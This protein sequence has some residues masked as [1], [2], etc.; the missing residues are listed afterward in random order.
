MSSK[1]LIAATSVIV[2]SKMFWSMSMPCEASSLSYAHWHKSS[3]ELPVLQT[4][5]SNRL[6]STGTL[7][8]LNETLQ[9]GQWV[10]YEGEWKT[11]AFIQ[12]LFPFTM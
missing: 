10:S 4:M 12:E 11:Q 2:R 5:D 6:R 8:F 9:G 3:G 7:L 1:T